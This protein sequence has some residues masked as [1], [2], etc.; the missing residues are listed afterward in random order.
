MNKIPRKKRRRFRAFTG[1]AAPLLILILFSGIVIPFPLRTDD[2][3]LKTSPFTNNPEGGSSRTFQ[4]GFA[5]IPRQHLT[6]QAWLD[7]FDLLKKNAEFV[8]HHARIEWEN[9]SSGEKTNRGREWESLKFISGM[10]E[11]YGL[12]LFLV[13][14]PLIP[15][16]SRRIIIHASGSIRLNPL[17]SPSQAGRPEGTRH[18]TEAK[19]TRKNSWQ[20]STVS[21]K[22][23]D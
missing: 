4:M 22:R 16:S 19:R 5:P 15:A 3:L 11:R 21:R 14:D 18:I 20:R 17:S 13:M 6:A 2:V 9:S 7:A 1:S 8:L 12:K 10:A 23:R